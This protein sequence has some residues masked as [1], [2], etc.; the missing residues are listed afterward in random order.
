MSKIT[1]ILPFASQIKGNIHLLIDLLKNVLSVE[2]IDLIEIAPFHSR[3]MI[4]KEGLSKEEFDIIDEELVDF[5]NFFRDYFLPIE[6]KYD[7]RIK[8]FKQTFQLGEPL[9]LDYNTNL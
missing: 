9:I 6:R 8:D 7:Y 3:F 4:H 5:F 1:Q 2:K